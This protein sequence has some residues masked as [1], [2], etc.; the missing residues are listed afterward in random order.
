MQQFKDLDVQRERYREHNDC[1]VKAIA[2]AYNISYGRAHRQLIKAGR[3]PRRATSLH[4]MAKAVNALT[5]NDV[6]YGEVFA[7][8]ICGVKNRQT[9]GS[10]CKDNPKGVYI[11]C[12]RSHAM[13]VRDGVL[14]DWTQEGPQRR[15]VISIYKV[16]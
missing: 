15:M 6:T 9:I 4:Q 10:F 14:I 13:C 8:M 1:A 16:K 11:I 5:G 12:S 7:E 3:T 2:A